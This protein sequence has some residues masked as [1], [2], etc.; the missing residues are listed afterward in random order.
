MSIIALDCVVA[1]DVSRSLDVDALIPALRAMCI[2][3]ESRTTGKLLTRTEVQS[4]SGSPVFLN[5][6]GPLPYDPACVFHLEMMISLAG[7]GKQYIGE[8]WYAPK[9]CHLRPK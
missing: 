9:I 4:E 2:L 1:E 5:R 8:T 6:E 3:A 7:R